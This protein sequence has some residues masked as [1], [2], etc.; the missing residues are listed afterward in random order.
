VVWGEIRALGTHAALATGGVGGGGAGGGGGTDAG[1]AVTVGAA[2]GAFALVGLTGAAVWRLRLGRPAGED[3]A[4]GPSARPRKSLTR[5]ASRRSLSL[6]FV[7]DAMAAAGSRGGD[8]WGETGWPPGNGPGPGGGPANGGHA[9]LG[10]VRGDGAG[11]YH[12]Q[13]AL[14][15]AE[16][17]RAGAP[18]PQVARGVGAVARGADSPTHSESAPGVPA[19]ASESP[20]A[21]AA[22]A[23]AGDGHRAAPNPG[24][25]S[26]FAHMDLIFYRGAAAAAGPARSY[27]GV[28]AAGSPELVRVSSRSASQ[29]LEDSSLPRADPSPSSLIIMMF[30]PDQLSL[31][32]TRDQLSLILTRDRSYSPSEM[33]Y[34]PDIYRYDQ[35]S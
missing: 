7:A 15:A 6:G 25:D 33:L 17:G 23:R 9:G 16:E 21:A 12:Q 22:H 14:A 10:H 3:G 1:T 19:A 4:G 32:F 27:G 26:E 34:T 11:D 35:I 2:L 18:A 13:G 20:E 29:V 31:M 5:T 30:T 8:N 28:A 24:V